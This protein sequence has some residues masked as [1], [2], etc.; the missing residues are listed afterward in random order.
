MKSGQKRTYTFD[1][2]KAKVIFKLLS[3][4]KIKLV[5]RHKVKTAEEVK[6]EKYCK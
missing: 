6:G 2:K 1:T 5:G 4:K 3:N